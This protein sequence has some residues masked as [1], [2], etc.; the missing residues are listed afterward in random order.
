MKRALVIVDHGSR[1]VEANEHL[2]HVAAEV[3]RLA[4]GLPVYVAHMDLASPSIDEAI[5]ACAR[6]GAEEVLV[7]PFFLVPGQHLREDIPALVGQAAARHPGVRV[8]VTEPLG[9]AAG[10]AELVLRTALRGREG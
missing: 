8:H 5:D 6:D 3:G 1:R 4:K 10:I 2:E 7:H 9:S